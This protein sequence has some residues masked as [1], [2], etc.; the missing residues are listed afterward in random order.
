MRCFIAVPVSAGLAATLGEVPGPGHGRAVA[1]ADLHLTLAFLGERGEEWAR[2]RW[3]LLAELASGLPAFTLTLPD[4][5]P[6][7]GPGGRFWAAR[8]APE[9]ALTALHGRLWRALAE[10]G[11]EPEPRA[12]LP[13][14]TLARLGHATRAAAVPGPWRMPVSSLA[15][16]ESPPAGG[17]YRILA[18]WPMGGPPT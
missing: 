15:F 4:A 18:Q 5:G 10:A 9:P 6:F 3:P 17:G 12:F 1:A 11:V 8:V 16:Y 2:A 14:V 7:P 13:H